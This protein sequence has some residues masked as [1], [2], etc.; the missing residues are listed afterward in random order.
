MKLFIVTSADVDDIGNLNSRVIKVCKTQEEAQQA[1]KE[2]HNNVPTIY[3]MSNNFDDDWTEDSDCFDIWDE[4]TGVT[5]VSA[6]IEEV[7]V[8]FNF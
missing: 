5:G 4:D 2:Y 6:N 7:D 8:D 1:I 3:H